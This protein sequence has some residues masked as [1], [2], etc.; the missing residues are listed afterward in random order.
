VSYPATG[1]INKKKKT[2][3]ACERNEEHR[4][5]Y[6]AHLMGV[7]V[8]KLV[9]VDESGFHLGMFVSLSRTMLPAYGRSPQRERCYAQTPHNR[10]ENTNLIAALSVHGVQATMTLEGNVDTEI[11]DLFIEHTLLPTLQS[12]QIVIWDNYKIHKSARTRQLIETQGCQ[13][14]T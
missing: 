7:D 1:W 2:L 10:G 14:I 8:H 6:L 5:T 12:G 9:F 13:V 4:L 3:S 11:F